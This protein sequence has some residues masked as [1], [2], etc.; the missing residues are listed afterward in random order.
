M[1]EIII[2]C[3]GG[4]RGNGKSDCASGWGV[5]LEYKGHKKELH[6]YDVGKTN[7]QMEL[8]ASIESLKALKTTHLTVKIHS[9]SQ[10][11]IDGITTSYKKWI[12][13]GWKTSAKT[14][15]KNKELWQELVALSE[16][17]SDLQ[18]VKVKGHVGIEGNERADQLANLAMDEAEE[19]IGKGD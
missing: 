17:Q 14:P 7:N 6:G 5:H 2:Y 10:Y 15:V 1:S 4:A 18:W 11:V 12:R 16:M 3:D 19:I 9:D 8:Q 13:Q